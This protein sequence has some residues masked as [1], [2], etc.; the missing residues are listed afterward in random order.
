MG[1][2]PK[3][4]ESAGTG[5][6]VRDRSRKGLPLLQRGHYGGDFMAAEKAQEFATGMGVKKKVMVVIMRR[7]QKRV[8]GV[9]LYVRLQH[10]K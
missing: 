3:P 8:A 1:E 6:R 7:G 2:G 5:N 4:D 10:G 9:T